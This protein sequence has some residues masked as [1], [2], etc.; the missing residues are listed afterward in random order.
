MV[1]TRR[2]INKKNIKNFNCNI[3]INSIWE[4]Y[5]NNVAMGKQLA[6]RKHSSICKVICSCQKQFHESVD[7]FTYVA[8]KNYFIARNKKYVKEHPEFTFFNELMEDVSKEY[9]QITGV[10][11]W[12]WFVL[13]IQTVIKAYVYEAAWGT[14]LSI[15]LI[16]LA[17]SKLDRIKADICADIFDI[18]DENKDNSMDENEFAKLAKVEVVI[19]APIDC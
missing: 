10:S 11:F 8:I 5:E 2:G 13:S 15:F 18:A 12:M 3:L 17:G 1:P 9:I 14:Y 7:H 4:K 19:S 16:V 6:P